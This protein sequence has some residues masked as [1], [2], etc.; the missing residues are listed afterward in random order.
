MLHVFA[1]VPRVGS[2][3]DAGEALGVIVTS[4]DVAI[5]GLMHDVSHADVRAA[6]LAEVLAGVYDVVWLGTPCASCSVLW[7]D[8]EHTPPRARH[9]PDG[10]DGLPAWQQEYLEKHNAFIEFS[11][12]L[13]LAAWRAGATYV[14]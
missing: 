12:E 9:A 2:F 3:T 8:G 4:V 10:V 6:L 13:A 14:I 7:L 5:G 1:G 11:C